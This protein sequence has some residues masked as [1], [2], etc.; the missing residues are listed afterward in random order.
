[1]KITSFMC[2]ENS[3]IDSDGRLNFNNPLM[4]IKLVNLPS[5]FSFCI[6]LG[7]TNIDKNGNDKLVIDLV[8]P[9]GSAINIVDSYLPESD[10]SKDVIYKGMLNLELR[11]I[12]FDEY[13][14]YTFKIFGNDEL[15]SSY[16]I[17]M[18]VDENVD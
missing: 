10:E 11:N 7:I 13:G 17:E 6:I 14:T 3:F 12:V 5:T 1:M 4:E 18:E 16:E 15:I 2:F 8:S 9:S